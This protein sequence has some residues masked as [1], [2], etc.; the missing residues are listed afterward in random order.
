[1]TLICITNIMDD[2]RSCTIRGQ[3]QVTCDGWEYRWSVDRNIEVA[4]G[5]ECRGCQ[6]KEAKHGLLCWECWES[7]STAAGGYDILAMRLAGVDRAIVRDN[8]G[9]RTQALGSIPIPAVRLMLDEL[10][11]YLRGRPASLDTWVSTET[12]AKAAIRF[13]R[14][15]A[16]A[17]KNHPTEELAHKINRTRCTECGQL[18]LV[19]NPVERLGGDVVVKCSNP[20]CAATIDQTSFEKIAAIEKPDPE[21]PIEV[22]LDA[23]QPRNQAGFFAEDLD[24]EKP[25]HQALLDAS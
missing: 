19:W 23:G 6:P 7:V 21:R 2:Q 14:A 10:S 24:P 11:S 22:I 9:I 3:H 20:D 12:G 8:G 16:S 13:G 17:V 1:M 18:T 4:S 5:R 25:E 15:Y